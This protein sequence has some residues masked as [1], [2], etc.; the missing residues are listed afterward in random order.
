MQLGP[1]ALAE[2]RA[3]ALELEKLAYEVSKDVYS[4]TPPSE[5]NPETNGQ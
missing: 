4:H 5:R 1:E 2:V 3:K